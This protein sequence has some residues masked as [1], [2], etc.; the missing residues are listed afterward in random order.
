MKHVEV[1]RKFALLDKNRLHE[2]LRARRACYVSQSRQVDEYFNAPD[3]DFLA[4]DPVSEW[5]RLRTEDSVASLNYKH[6]LPEGA[7][8]KTHCDEFESQ[9]ADP[10]AVRLLLSALG[11]TPLV[12]VDKRRETWTLGSVLVAID[13]VAA[14]GAFVEF[15]YQGQ[16]ST[17]H[18][19]ATE[20][21]ALVAGLALS[22][23]EIDR[24]GYPY[25]LLSQRVL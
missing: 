18:E 20:L 6:W 23:G 14:L 19:A 12:V 3:R 10:T 21:D 15:E 5:L 11:Y 9:V 24:R 8:V 2:V 25:Q 22:L 1:E 4:D 13:D 17:V 7:D 16:A